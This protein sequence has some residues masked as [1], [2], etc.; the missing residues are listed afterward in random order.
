MGTVDKSGRHWIISRPS[1]N[2]F[3]F[4]PPFSLDAVSELFL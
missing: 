1:V 3:H 2:L 4:T